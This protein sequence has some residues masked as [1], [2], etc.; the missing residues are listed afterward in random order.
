[1]LLCK[2]CGGIVA[3]LLDVKVILEHGVP[4]FLVKFVRPLWFSI[5]LG[6]WTSSS[7]FHKPAD[8]LERDGSKLDV[9][10]SATR[11]A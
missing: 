6:K 10:V 11:Q 9:E 4:F 5:I 7:P 8:K 3:H 1:M 2:L